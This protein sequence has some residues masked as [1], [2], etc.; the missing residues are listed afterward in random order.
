MDDDREL[1]MPV[2][3]LRDRWERLKKE[4]WIALRESALEG[5]RELLGPRPRRPREGV[6]SSVLTLVARN[7]GLNTWRC[8]L[9]EVEATYLTD[10]I[11]N[12]H[13]RPTFL[14]KL[15]GLEL[16][17]GSRFRNVSQLYP[18]PEGAPTRYSELCKEWKE[19]RQHV[20]MCLFVFTDLE[21]LPGMEPILADLRVEFKKEGR[22]FLD[23]QMAYEKWKRLKYFVEMGF[24]LTYMSWKFNCRAD[25]LGETRDE[26]LERYGRMGFS[27]AEAI[28]VVS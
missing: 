23:R 14:E 2:G 12:A 16:Q 21:P 9:N 4:K 8:L 19:T 13:V 28:L 25:V 6:V 24:V 5:T 1:G 17:L 20:R 10:L 3:T 26:M 27:E 7:G 18:N 11:D 22:D 15:R